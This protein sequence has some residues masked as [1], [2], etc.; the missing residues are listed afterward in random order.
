MVHDRSQPCNFL[1]LQSS[2]LRL[3]PTRLYL[4]GSCRSRLSCKGSSNRA[5]KDCGTCDKVHWA[6]AGTNPAL[7]DCSRPDV[8]A[9]QQPSA[10]ESETLRRATKVKF[11]QSGL[12]VSQ[13][14]CRF[15][16]APCQT[17][18]V[19][20]WPSFTHHSTVEKNYFCLQRFQTSSLWTI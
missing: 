7:S 11:K 16:L 17:P 4:S 9:A 3:A 10:P 14:S 20:F 1:K 6:S 13:V 2:K 12:S 15:S 5:S 8:L 18:F 19:V